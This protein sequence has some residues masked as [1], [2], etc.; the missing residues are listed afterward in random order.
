MLFGDRPAMDIAAIRYILCMFQA[1]KILC[2]IFANSVSK[3]S[4]SAYSK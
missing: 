2:V 4:K 3:Q 1:D